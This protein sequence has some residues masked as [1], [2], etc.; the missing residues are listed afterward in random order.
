[1]ELALIILAIA[2]VVAALIL[3]F[4]R[5][6]PAPE[7]CLPSVPDPRLDEVIR[8]QGAIAEQFRQTSVQVEALKQRLGESLTENATKTA[9]TLG[10]IG[11]RLSVIDD[12]QKN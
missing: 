8:G 3:A 5:G 4:V 7:P 1:M 2:V 11:A 9:E 12:A 10:W 6:K